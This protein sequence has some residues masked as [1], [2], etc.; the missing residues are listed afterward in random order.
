MGGRVTLNCPCAHTL[1]AHFPAGGLAQDGPAE[2]MVPGAPWS[3][4]GRPAGGGGSDAGSSWAGAGG[5]VGGEGG[6]G[7]VMLRKHRRLAAWL[8]VRAQLCMSLVQL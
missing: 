1:C 8:R 5:G 2:P 4:E 3:P 7:G 6:R